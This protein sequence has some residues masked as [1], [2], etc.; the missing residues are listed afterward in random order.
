[1]EDSVTSRT[2]LLFLT[3]LTL[4]WGC[5]DE[6]ENSRK[7]RNTIDMMMAGD[8]VPGGEAPLGGEVIAGEIIAGEVIAGEVIAGEVIAGEEPGGE[9]V[10]PCLAYSPP[11]AD[12]DDP[13][14]NCGE[15]TPEVRCA[16]GEGVDDYIYKLAAC[17]ECYASEGYP[18]FA[19]VSC[20]EICDNSNDDDIDGFID[21]E[22]QDCADIPACEDL[23][24]DPPPI[25]T[26]M[27]CHNSTTSGLNDYSGPGITNPHPFGTASAIPCTTCHG[28]NGQGA[29]K[30]GSHVAPHPAIGNKTFQQNNP[31]AAF[32][33]I[34]L[35]GIDKLEPAEY[36]GAGCPDETCTNLDYLQFINPGDLR[37]V[38]QGRGC[39]AGGCHAGEHAEWVPRSA[40]ATT[41]GFFSGTRFMIGA[42]NR[43]VENR[44]SNNPELLEEGDA[45]SGSAPRAIENP[46]YNANNRL[47]GEVNRLVEQPEVAQYNTGDIYN[48]FNY[49][50]NALP[51]DIDNTDPQRPNRVRTGSN[52]ERLIDE[53]VSITC[54]NCHLY[55]AGA[56][57]RYADFRSSG[58]T[59]CHMEYSLDGRSRSTDPNVDS[60]EPANPD[61]IDDGERAHVADHIIRN[62][63]RQ[64]G[65]VFVR[66]IT[67]R[68]CVGCHQGS[69]RTVLQYWG[70]RL[71]ENKDLTNTVQY[72]ENPVD[73]D[74]TEDDPR[75]FDPAVNNDTFNGRDFQQYLLKEDYD[76]DGLDDTPPDVHYEAGMGCIDCH[77]SRDLHG[78]TERDTSSGK[79]MSRQDQVTGVS[80]ESC[81][82]ALDQYATVAPCKDYQDQDQECV[83]DRFGNPMRHVIKDAQDN[84]WLTSRVYGSLHY[85][86][87]VRD[88]TYNTERSHPRTGNLLYSPKAAYAMGRINGTLGSGP[89]QQDPL[90]YTQGFSH[91]DDLDCS[92]CHASWTN[93]CIGCHL[94]GEYD[95]DPAQF[96]FSN[97]TG[98]RIVVKEAAANFVYQNPIPTYLGINSRGYITQ[99][100]PAEK[101]FYR[102]RDINETDSQVFAFSDRLGEGNNPNRLTGNEFP[103]LAMNQMAPHSIR[104]RLDPVGQNEGL[105]YCVTCHLTD[106]SIGNFGTQYNEFRQFYYNN[107]FQ[108]LFDNGLLALLREHIGLNPGNQIDS[109]FFVHMVAGLGS[110]LFLFDANGCPVNPFDTNALRQN[111]NGV[112]PADNFDVN[113]VAYDLDRIVE[114]TGQT[115]SGSIHPRL[116]DGLPYRD[117]NNRMMAG[118]LNATLLQRLTDPDTGLV[119][120]AWL[121]A[122][123]DAQGN[124][125]DYI[126]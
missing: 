46:A 77:G 23:I 110:S 66:G 22:D 100:S 88:L 40:I 103:A 16:N 4:F 67:D 7:P 68:A 81:H 33:R 1:M 48:N 63:T 55:S 96:F 45:L 52:L 28:G 78:G 91:L 51:N 75:L 36:P 30:E 94:K 122:N 83:V 56:N 102:Y 39:G 72:P 119:L 59:A 6:P 73:F 27:L 29:G 62:V 24:I 125:T 79:I 49:D 74:D 107:D 32:N 50:S 111:C 65:G 26:C 42:E 34:T 2:I 37:V 3:L 9:E 123:G 99:I 121:D 69:N 12:D 18:G 93:N 64:V 14:I 15:L 53:Q 61:Q 90:S 117:G 115:N 95:A 105:R 114:I 106:A 31:Q 41:N 54:G 92:S 13:A 57:D 112:A 47:V 82:G 108:A 80:C 8:E 44:A 20:P 113:N 19:N 124:A 76:G 58:C 86:P 109:P 84:Y 5:D 104:G 43:V 71:D 97:I 120:D 25:E 118:P 89:L 98:E 17:A 10:D 38:A 35:A 87:Q 21:C 11:Y 116:S 70:I 60:F 126:Q 85:V 101:M